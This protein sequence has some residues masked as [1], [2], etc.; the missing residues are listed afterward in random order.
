MRYRE[1]PGRRCQ[2]AQEDSRVSDNVPIR[3]IRGQGSPRANDAPRRSPRF[4]EYIS[5]AVMLYSFGARQGEERGVVESDLVE[6]MVSPDLDRNVITTALVD[7]R[8]AAPRE[9][10]SAGTSPRSA[11][12]APR[13]RRDERPYLAD[14]TAYK[15]L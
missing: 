1:R 4:G 7:P 2:L 14:L 10:A 3:G 13:R 5:L 6:T 12:R 8:R 11:R 15:P 9:L